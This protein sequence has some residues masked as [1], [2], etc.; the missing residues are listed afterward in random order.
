M[1]P[2]VSIIMVN[3]NG[4]LDTR[5]LLTSLGKSPELELIVVDNGSGIDETSLLQEEFS[6]VKFIRS[7]KNMG[8]AGGNNLGLKV[9]SGELLMLLN[10]DTLVSSKSILRMAVK[11][12][13]LPEID[14]LCPILRFHS[15]GDIQYA[16]Y[17]DINPVTGR[18]RCIQE[19]EGDKEIY[20]TALP[21]GAAMMFTRHSFSKVGLMPED[22]F[23]YYEEH[24][25]GMSFKRAHFK[26]AVYTKCE[27]FHKE[28]ASVGKI[29]GLKAYY[30]ERNRILFMRR[31]VSQNQLAKFLAYYLFLALPKSLF[32]HAIRG[33]ISNVKAAL[34]GVFSQFEF[35]SL[36]KRKFVLKQKPVD[37]VKNRVIVSGF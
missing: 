36:P 12:M 8:F 27:V 18:N 32:L 26:I 15:T 5:E 37:S 11:L 34:A 25:W 31:N 20:E 9:A 21:H 10:N 33:Q 30:L 22:Y 24:D 6:Y 16:G 19:L 3:F 35:K 17:T 28:S 23:L 7:E 4:I 2:L 14:V 13:S 1:K 29:S